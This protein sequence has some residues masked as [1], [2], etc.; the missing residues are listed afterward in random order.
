MHRDVTAETIAASRRYNRRNRGLGQQSIDLDFASRAE[1]YPSIDAYR[2]DET[3]CHRGAIPL[4][5]LL[6]RIN[7]LAAFCSIERVKHSRLVVGTV[8]CFGGDG[9]HDAILLAI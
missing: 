2:N 4:A 5:V 1:V 7:G 9:P 8:P 3:R 6:G